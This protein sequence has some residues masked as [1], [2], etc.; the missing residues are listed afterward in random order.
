[1]KIGSARF[2]RGQRTYIAGVINL[3]PDSFSDGGAVVDPQQA[4][5]RAR[6]LVAEGAD[7]IDLG[8]ESARPGA[9]PISVD[10]ELARLLPALRAVRAAVTVPI[11][12]D[13]YKS[14]VAGAAVRTGADLINDIS[15]LR[16]DPIMA[17]TVAAFDV[18]VIIMHRRPFNSPFGGD[19]WAGVLSELD[20]SLGK[21]AAA[22][23]P[24]DKIILDPGFGF[25]KTDAQNLALVTG[26]QHLQARGYPTML[27]PARKSTLGRILGLPPAERLEGTIALA[28]LAVA[29]GV[30]WL[31]I[32]DV[33]AVA[34]A[35]KVADAAV[36]GAP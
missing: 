21:A 15:G 31:R 3:T 33:Q 2:P 20:I 36:R 34:R 29:Q 13:T 27:G 19:L 30:D 7:L 1:M 12:V 22:R 24:A 4:V 35:V 25:G 11:S 32:H 10:T 26:L 8:A 23:I 5:E 9:Y 16:A 17:A 14:D 28:V 18:P 6:Q